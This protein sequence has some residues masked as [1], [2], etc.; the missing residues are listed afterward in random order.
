L[1]VGERFTSVCLT[2]HWTLP[3]P[4][5]PAGRKASFDVPMLVRLEARFREAVAQSEFS[6]YDL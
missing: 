3:V 4:H 2:D 1:H 6:S 5:T